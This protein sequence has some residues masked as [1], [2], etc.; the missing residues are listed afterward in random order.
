MAVVT[1]AQGAVG[2]TVAGKKRKGRVRED[3]LLAGKR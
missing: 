2:W 3:L 1:A